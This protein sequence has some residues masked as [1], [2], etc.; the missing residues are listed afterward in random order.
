M[1]DV[2]GKEYVQ[3]E[4]ESSESDDDTEDMEDIEDDYDKLRRSRDLIPCTVIVPLVNLP[5]STNIWCMYHAQYSCPC[6]KY[7][8]PLDF[9]P[10][11]E[12]GDIS[13]SKAD[14]EKLE[15]VSKKRKVSQD[16]VESKGKSMAARMMVGPKSRMKKSKIEDEPLLGIEDIDP[17]Y[18]KPV[19]SS[20]RHPLSAPAAQKLKM[21]QS[22]R[23][24]P[25]MMKQSLKTKLTIKHQKKPVKNSKIP[26][27]VKIIDDDD[28][29]DDDVIEDNQDLQ[30]SNE[31]NLDIK[32]VSSV[33][34]VRWDIIKSKF[35]TNDI[36]LYFWVRPGRGRNILF[37]TQSGA[38]PHIASAI[39]LRNIQGST[40]HLPSL[41]SDSINV[42]QER[43]KARYCI[44]E[45]NGSMW[46]IT[47]LMA[48]KGQKDL[49]LSMETIESK[50]VKK[51]D[52]S[53][54]ESSKSNDQKD[55][56]V[57]ISLDQSVQK[58][59]VGQSLI[60]V[61]EGAG[62]KAL[63]QVKLPPTLNNQYWSLISVG[64]GQSSIQCPDSNLVLKCAILQQAATLST[65]TST[66]VRIPI[67]VA[68]QVMFT[69]YC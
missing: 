48:I 40:H 37:L 35:Q 24:K 11:I 42:V 61:V 46:S 60:T 8:N 32:D 33:Q 15:T 5:S 65:A 66:T 2:A 38:K 18:Q 69:F 58:L 7:K 9:A 64:Q 57:K 23:T 10:D 27:L 54:T 29:E 62:N 31:L 22:A 44:L 16:S 21:I 30:L 59:P 50:M 3:K 4:D 1:L 41:V 25:M 43:D 13:V 56:S 6:N 45:S 19:P 67:P 20:V 34:Y 26:E 47:K 28:A 51:K 55:S 49:G 17:D 39:N 63:M 53:N 36:D 14:A 68:D 12:H 52:P